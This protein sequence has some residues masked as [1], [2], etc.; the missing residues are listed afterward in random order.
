MKTFFSDKNTQ[1]RRKLDEQ[2]LTA[3]HQGHIDVPGAAPGPGLHDAVC[4]HSQRRDERDD[5]APSQAAGLRLGVVG[6]STAHSHAQRV[7]LGLRVGI[8]GV[9]GCCV[10][11][12]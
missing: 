1:L 6:A 3:P 9:W 5:A 7:S 2:L 8:H 12:V 11:E 10:A 4:E